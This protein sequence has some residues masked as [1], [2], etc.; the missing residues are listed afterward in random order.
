MKYNSV[1]SL[2]CLPPMLDSILR[3][4]KQHQLCTRFIYKHPIKILIFQASKANAK[5][6]ARMA[7]MRER[8]LHTVNNANA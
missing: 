4:N 7:D 5:A 2:G 3:K 8:V 1:D 6:D